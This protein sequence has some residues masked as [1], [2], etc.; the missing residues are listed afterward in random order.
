MPAVHRVMLDHQHIVSVGEF[1]KRGSHFADAVCNR[2]V[3]RMEKDLGV[4]P[5]LQRQQE[6]TS[7]VPGQQI[8]KDMALSAFKTVMANRCADPAEGFIQGIKR[9]VVAVV[10]IA[11]GGGVA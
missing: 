2:V 5:D 11:P 7:I 9:A 1:S 6:E 3:R 10:R 4:I 8:R